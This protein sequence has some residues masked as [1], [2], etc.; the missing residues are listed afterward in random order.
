MQLFLD[1]A[2]L[3]EIEQ[4]LHW[5]L[6]DGLTTNPSLLAREG[7]DWEKQAREICRLVKGPVSLEVTATDYEGMLEEARRLVTFA[8][9][10]VIKVPMTPEGL[11]VVPILR[12]KDIETNM[13]LVFSAAQALLAARAGASYVSPFV[14]R[15]DALSHDGMH[16]VAEILTIYRNYNYQT[17]VIVASVRHPKHVIDAALLGADA[18]TIPYNVMMQLMKHPLTDSGLDAFLND[19]AKLKQEK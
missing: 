6:I 17:K 19:W 2:K 16:L 18:A 12:R 8:P 11:R 1:S 10:V 3:S 15:L 9:N 13:T 4:A 7:G 5:G 14:G